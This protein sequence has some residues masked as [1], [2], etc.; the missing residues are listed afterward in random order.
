MSSCLMPWSILINF[1]RMHQCSAYYL[2]P[3]F[4]GHI[5][6][7]QYLPY[8]IKT[9]FI[10]LPVYYIFLK[11]FKKIKDL[12]FINLILNLAT[13][14]IVFF[15][16]SAICFKYDISYLYYLLSAE[17]Y[18]PLIEILILKYNMFRGR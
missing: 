15:V 11:E 6:F 7:A 1:F 9:F 12:L 13:H 3:A 8:F 17:I 2:A 16:I 10:E 18:A 5:T 4:D 14:P